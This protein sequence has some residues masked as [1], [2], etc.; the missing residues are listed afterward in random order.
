MLSYN[1][2][3][4][5]QRRRALRWL[6]TSGGPRAPR[7]CDLCRARDGKPH[8][9]SYAEPWGA[10][11]GAYS[12]CGRCHRAVHTRARYPIAWTRLR[13][14]AEEAGRLAVAEAIERGDAFPPAVVDS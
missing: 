10:H 9:E 4:P 1:G 12:L 13:R 11:I 2:F 3:S 8:S 6:R 5:R 7:P 14:I